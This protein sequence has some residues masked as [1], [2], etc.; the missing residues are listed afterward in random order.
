MLTQYISDD[1]K[2]LRN[3]LISK[4]NWLFWWTST[5]YPAYDRHCMNV[6]EIN[7]LV[8]E[9]HI[10]IWQ[11]NKRRALLVRWMEMCQDIELGKDRDNLEGCG[12]FRGRYWA[13]LPCFHSHPFPCS[14]VSYLELLLWAVLSGHLQ[15]AGFAQERPGQTLQTRRQT[16]HRAFLPDSLVCGSAPG[17]GYVFWSASASQPW[18]LVPLFS[19]RSPNLR[20]LGVLHLLTSELFTIPRLGPQLYYFLLS[21]P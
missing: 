14:S 12:K 8:L 20:L 6:C 16:E 3:R 11:A 21:N 10:G 17:G 9:R 18:P 4:R 5:Q 13:C 15:E 1:Q 19:H 7:V 2:S